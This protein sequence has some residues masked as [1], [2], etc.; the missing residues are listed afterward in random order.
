MT[1]FGLG[2]TRAVHFLRA[3]K[4]AQSE[5]TQLRCSV[6]KGTGEPRRG[7]TL[8][9]FLLIALQES[10]PLHST[11]KLVT[12]LSAPKKQPGGHLRATVNCPLWKF[13]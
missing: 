2:R 9:T 7:H 3:M 13:F 4:T 5:A 12:R 10:L 8:P 1:L 6:L 11:A